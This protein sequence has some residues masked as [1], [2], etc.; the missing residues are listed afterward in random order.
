[1]NIK[2]IFDGY[3][4][5]TQKDDVKLN[6]LTK[7]GI[8]DNIGYL[9]ILNIEGFNVCKI[10]TSLNV[11]KRISGIRQVVRCVFPHIENS[12]HYNVFISKPVS[13]RFK[14]EKKNT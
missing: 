7:D 5:V 8:T 3:G 10:G 2:Y 4:E 6:L 14:L 13:D 12:I 11:F 1:M 9:Y